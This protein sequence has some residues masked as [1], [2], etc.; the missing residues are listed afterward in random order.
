MKYTVYKCITVWLMP[1][2]KT[3]RIG[4]FAR[5]NLTFWCLTRKRFFFIILGIDDDPE[6]MLRY[7]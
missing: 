1:H 2:M 7:L 4:S 5:N 3:L 6:D